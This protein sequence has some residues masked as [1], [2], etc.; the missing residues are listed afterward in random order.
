MWLLF[1]GSDYLRTASK[2]STYVKTEHLKCD[3]YFRKNRDPK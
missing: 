1:E 3:T 2:Y